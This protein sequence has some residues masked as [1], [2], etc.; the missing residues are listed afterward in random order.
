M[1]F[2]VLQEK[3]SFVF[4]NLYKLRFQLVYIV[5]LNFFMDDISV[6]KLKKMEIF[7]LYIGIFKVKKQML[8]FIKFVSVFV[9]VFI[10]EMVCVVIDDIKNLEG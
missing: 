8:S 3:N 4:L 2:F 1:L 6:N 7:L 9:E 5:F 10:F